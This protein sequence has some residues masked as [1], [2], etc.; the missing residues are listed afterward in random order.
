MRLELTRV[1]YTPSAEEVRARGASRGRL[2]AA[3]AGPTRRSTALRRV[4]AV[5]AVFL[6]GQFAHEAFGLGGPGANTFFDS[7][8][9]DGLIVGAAGLCFARAFVRRSERLAWASFGCGLAAF[10]TGE[11]VWEIFYANVDGVTIADV[12]WLAWYP[13][14]FAGIGLL[15]LARVPK[16]EVHRWIDGIAV[17]L[18]IATPGVALVLQPVMEEARRGALANAVETTY[19]LADIVLLGA[20]VGVL[21]LIGRRA[22]RSWILLSVGLALF[23]VADSLYSVD[24]IARTYA[25]GH[26]DYLY[27]AAAL[28]VGWAA[29]QPTTP[30]RTVEVFGWRAIALPLSCQ[31]L[32]IGIQVYA[33]LYEIPDSERLLTIAVLCVAVMQIVVTRPVRPA[34]TRSRAAPAPSPDSA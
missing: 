19:P 14:A 20:A 34:A 28:V 15:V 17:A 22:G 23:V 11:V 3:W 12:F 5:F 1:S 33:F 26:F 29:W 31:A 9:H 8:V 13:F 32:A 30:H 4:L 10:A 2:P 25:P 16:F 7:V 6:A 21:A 18:L 27:P 24:V